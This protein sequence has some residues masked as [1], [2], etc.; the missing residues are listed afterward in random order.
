MS[1]PRD[2]SLQETMR[3]RRQAKPLLTVEELRE[4]EAE[5]ERAETESEAARLIERLRET[6]AAVDA[7]SGLAPAVYQAV[8]AIDRDAYYGSR[9]WARRAKA[10][11][12]AAPH[13]EVDRC[14]ER[15]ELQVRHL[16]HRALGAEQ[17]GVDLITLC[18]SCERRAQRQARDRGRL[19]TRKEIAKLDP[20]QPLYEPAAIAALKA[21]YAR[22]LRPA[23]VGRSDLR[24]L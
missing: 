9:H 18:D 4:R 21:R 17:V 5:R 11:R 6:K 15:A 23:D 19:L 1:K 7:D 3:A 22:P 16:G 20:L 24:G 13:C 12:A 10:Q 14:T 2:R 8:F